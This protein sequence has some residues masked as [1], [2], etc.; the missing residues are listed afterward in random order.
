MKLWVEG[1]ASLSRPCEMNLFMTPENVIE[2]WR[3][4]KLGYMEIDSTLDQQLAQAGKTGIMH[5]CLGDKSIGS[6]HEA[7]LK[8]VDYFYVKGLYKDKVKSKGRRKS[9]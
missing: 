7:V 9:K 2:F 6:W 3:Q 5:C 4:N 1:P 8:E